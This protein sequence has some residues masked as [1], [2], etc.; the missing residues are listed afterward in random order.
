MLNISR[1]VGRGLLLE[2]DYNLKKA[3]ANVYI[4]HTESTRHFP[5]SRRQRSIDS[6]WRK[7]W[8]S[9]AAQVH[10]H[11]YNTTSETHFRI[12]KDKHSV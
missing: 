12:Y 11:R 2:T 4:F 3:S 7:T 1:W 9:L 5:W 10:S 8:I 6:E